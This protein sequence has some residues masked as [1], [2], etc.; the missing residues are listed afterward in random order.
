MKKKSFKKC[1]GGGDIPLPHLI[2]RHKVVVVV[3]I[4][5]VPIVMRW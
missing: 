1:L 3:V 2:L 5:P 4:I